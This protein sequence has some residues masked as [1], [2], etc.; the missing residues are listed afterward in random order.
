MRIRRAAT[1]AAL[2]LLVGALSACGGG[3]HAAGARLAAGEKAID[4]LAIMGIERDW[5]DAETTLN[6]AKMMSLWAPNATWQLDPA[7]TLVGKRQIRAFWIKQVFPLARK[8]HWFSDTA[9]FRIRVGVDGS[10][11]TLYFECHEI[12][13]QTKK[14]VLIVGQ[15]L[16]VAKIGGRWLITKSVGSSPTIGA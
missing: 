13:R 3:S 8:Q 4:Q 12:D 7:Q 10:R 2:A 9:T 15:D 14:V 1:A 6:L 11:G 16:D 5:H